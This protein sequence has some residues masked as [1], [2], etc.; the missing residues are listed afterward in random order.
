MI[1][2][3]CNVPLFREVV[4]KFDCYLTTVIV[5]DHGIGIYHFDK[6]IQMTLNPHKASAR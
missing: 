4:G 2:S 1:V 3:K 6:S 5:Q